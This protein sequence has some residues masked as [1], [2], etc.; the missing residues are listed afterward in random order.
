MQYKNLKNSKNNSGFVILFT[1]LISSVVL[2]VALGVSSVATKELV[3]TLSA[4]EGHLAF[5]AADTGLDCAL[6]YDRG[7][8]IFIEF[9]T[10]TSVSCLTGTSIP[11]NQ[12]TATTFNFTYDTTPNS[13]SCFIVTIDKDADIG[14]GARGTVITSRGYNICTTNANNP[15]LVERKLEAVY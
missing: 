10:V 1:V 4:K 9:P 11:V 13:Q 15:R 3:L 2:L 5:F 6:Y 8:N 14:G 12:T 7:K